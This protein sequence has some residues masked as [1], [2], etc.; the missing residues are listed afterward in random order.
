MQ[1]RC[2]PASGSVWAVGGNMCRSVCL[3]VL[4]R[5]IGSLEMQL[6]RQTRDTSASARRRL[7]RAPSASHSH[8]TVRF[9]GFFRIFCAFL[10]TRPPFH[11]PLRNE[12][13]L[14]HTDGNGIH[15][16]SFFPPCPVSSSPPRAFLERSPRWT[17]PAAVL[18]ASP[19][20]EFFF[21]R[22]E[23]KTGKPCL[24]AGQWY[25]DV[26]LGN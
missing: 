6:S 3:G 13:F 4:E 20:P 25:P 8:P 11:K 18:D 14:V 2:A 21:R 10:L 12:L 1:V 7:L 26:H 22:Q 9:L 23:K 24:L 17:I 19:K 5:G 16:S 15:L